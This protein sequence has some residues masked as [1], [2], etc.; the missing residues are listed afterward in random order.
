MKNSKS[1]NDLIL[2]ITH[3]PFQIAQ[4]TKAGLSEYH[5]LISTIPKARSS[6][7]RQKIK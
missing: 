7:M 5:K 6:R 2:T 3:L 1:T 4:E